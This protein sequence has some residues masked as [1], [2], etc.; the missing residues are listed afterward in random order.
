MV[1]LF[2]LRE[3]GAHRPVI[4]WL[5]WDVVYMQREYLYYLGMS[6]LLGVGKFDLTCIH[7]FHK[8][9]FS[10]TKAIIQSSLTAC[11]PPE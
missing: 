2:P 10:R 6:D 3:R 1:L 11:K 5:T 9:E 7:A 8:S 4:A